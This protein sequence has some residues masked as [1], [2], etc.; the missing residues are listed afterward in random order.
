M[1]RYVIG[2]DL[3]FLMGWKMDERG[4]GITAVSATNFESVYNLQKQL[5][6]WE[7]DVTHTE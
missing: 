4:W 2:W 6:K 1:T 3:N 5:E 7:I